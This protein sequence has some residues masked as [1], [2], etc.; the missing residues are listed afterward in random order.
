MVLV[1]FHFVVLVCN[2]TIIIGY[3]FTPSKQLT[4]FRQSM[5]ER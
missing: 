4:L 5:G 3:N 1:S 2:Y